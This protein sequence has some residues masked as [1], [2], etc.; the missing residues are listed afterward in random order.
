[1][2]LRAKLA[3]GGGVFSVLVPARRVYEG[4]S[5]AGAGG[6]TPEYCV[7]SAPACSKPER[8]ISEKARDKGAHLPGELQRPLMRQ[9]GGKREALHKEGGCRTECCVDAPQRHSSAAVV[10]QATRPPA[11]E[12]RLRLP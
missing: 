5:A 11:V 2:H 9:A 4:A 7:W 3:G 10:V 8:N 12:Q 6:P 1:M